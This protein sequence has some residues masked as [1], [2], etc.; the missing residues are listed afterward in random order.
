MDLG[1]L[2][3]IDTLRTLPGL[4][5]VTWA[6]VQFIKGPADKVFGT[7]RTRYLAFVVAELILFTLS[8]IDGTIGS[9]SV[10]LNLLNGFIVALAT[11]KGH[12]V[13]VEKR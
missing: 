7:I 13:F 2:I 12:E 4:V 8:F 11:M 9:E 10:I 6:V 5:A 3:S 1:N